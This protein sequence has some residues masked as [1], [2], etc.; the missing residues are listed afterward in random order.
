M[1]QRPKALP[2]SKVVSETNEEA[3]SLKACQVV[4]GVSNPDIFDLSCLSCR[5]V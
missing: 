4:K 1:I 2:V 3:G 5:H